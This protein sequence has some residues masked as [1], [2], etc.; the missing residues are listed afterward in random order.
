MAVRVHAHEQ[1]VVRHEDHLAQLV[2]AQ[3]VRQNQ[4]LRAG[5]W[6]RDKYERA[7]IVPNVNT[8]AELTAR[9]N[10]ALEQLEVTVLPARVAPRLPLARSLDAVVYAAVL[11]NLV[12]DGRRAP[13]HHAHVVQFVV[14]KRDNSALIVLLVRVL[15]EVVNLVQAVDDE[16]R[17]PHGAALVVL[18]IARVNLE[19]DHLATLQAVDV[20]FHD[21]ATLALLRRL[22]HFRL[23]VEKDVDK[24]CSIVVVRFREVQILVVAPDHLELDGVVRVEPDVPFVLLLALP[25]ILI[26]CV[27]NNSLL[28]NASHEAS[29]DVVCELQDHG[30]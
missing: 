4:P 2:R 23:L 28:L 12:A 6:L 30:L 13:W 20:F 26:L 9:A 1:M 21:T 15:P 18:H 16:E 22:G 17:V 24:I 25:V 10:L 3:L 11:D 14:S 27:L 19:A 29:V 5:G 7:L 8:Q